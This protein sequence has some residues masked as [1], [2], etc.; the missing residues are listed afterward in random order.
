MCTCTCICTYI[1]IYIH[2]HTYI[3][4]LHVDTEAAGTCAACQPGKFKNITGTAKCELCTANT[5][6]AIAVSADCVA[7][8]IRAGSYAGNTECQC[9]RHR[10]SLMQG[11]FADCLCVVGSIYAY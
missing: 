4:I 3:Y 1:Y 2:T 9:L 7:C 6:G 11:P 5:D 10:T 8:L